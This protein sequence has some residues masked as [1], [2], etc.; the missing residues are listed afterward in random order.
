MELNGSSFGKGNWGARNGGKTGHLVGKVSGL[1]WL[2]VLGA[3]SLLM[4]E[5][6]MAF[7]P[8]LLAHSQLPA[9]QP[10]CTFSYSQRPPLLRPP[11]PSGR[12]SIHKGRKPEPR[13]HEP[14]PT[15]QPKNLH[16]DQIQ[17]FRSSLHRQNR[18]RRRH[19]HLSLII[20]RQNPQP[21]CNVGRLNGPGLNSTPNQARPIMLLPFQEG[22]PNQ[23]HRSSPPRNNRCAC[24]VCSH[25]P[26]SNRP[27]W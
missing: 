3:K 6:I 26:R 27:G 5:S 22:S 9:F 16:I 14:P 7:P 10:K 8:R 2:D 21:C 17:G 19:L 15:L 20:A 11:G 13:N 1:E 4:E 23:I 12:Y 24:A 18:P 25:S